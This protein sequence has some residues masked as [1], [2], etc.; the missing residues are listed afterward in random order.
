M[1]S[2]Q[3]LQDIVAGLK[4]M[5]PAQAPLKD[6]IATNTLYAFQGLSFHEGLRQAQQKLGVRTYLDL[7]EYQLLFKAGKINKSVLEWLVSKQK[8][9]E[10]KSQNLE[11]VLEKISETEDSNSAGYR[12]RYRL[13]DLWKKKHELNIIT[14]VHPILFRHMGHFLDQGISFSPV[15]FLRLGFW[16]SLQELERKSFH[17]IFKGGSKSRA[18]HLLFENSWKALAE[19][20]Q[21]LVG[22]E[23]LYERY[24]FEMVQEHPGWSGLVSVIE[25]NPEHLNFSRQIPLHETLAFELLL[26]IDFIDSQLKK[27]GK[28]FCPL[29]NFQDEIDLIENQ[30]P[31]RKESENHLLQLFHNAWEWTNYQELLTGLQANQNQEK[32]RS[33]SAQ[34]FFCIDDRCCSIR[35]HLEEVNPNLETFATPGFF[36]VEFWYKSEWDRFPVKLCPAPLT[37]NFL[38]KGS[39]EQGPKKIVI[40]DALFTRLSHTIFGGWLISQTFGLLSAFRMLLNVLSPTLSPRVAS[41]F[42]HT[43]DRIKLRI[44]RRAENPTEKGLFLGFDRNEMADRVY[45]LLRSSGLTENFSDLVVMMGHGSSTVNNPHYAAY[46]CGAC[47]GRPGSINARIFCMIANDTQVRELVG[48]KGLEIPKTTRFVPGLFD[49]TRDEV[50][51]YDREELREEHL[52]KLIELRKDLEEALLRNSKERSRRFDD[53]SLEISPLEA[54]K[55]LRKKSISIF[56]PRQ[57]FTHS[58]NHS[59]IIGP[60]KLTRGLFLDRRSFMNSYE[61]SLDPQGEIL[62]NILKAAVPVC[63]GINLQYFFSR[64]DNEK[65][66]SGT[67]LPHNV[68]G[69]LSIANGS[70]GDLR[71]GLPQ[72]MI[73]WHEPL[74]L[75]IIVYQEADIALKAAKKIQATFEWIQNDWVKYVSIS[76]TT[77]DFFLFESGEMNRF[78]FFGA[79]P[80]QVK[81]SM[82]LISRS[83][84]YLPVTLIREQK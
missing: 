30:D 20:L 68:V 41:S 71:P 62:C 63:G 52:K 76:P 58:G 28:S 32:V 66:G 83:R 44:F 61:P 8:E 13:R 12:A 24:L 14:H 40:T 74:R 49:T 38:I 57:E 7:Q 78:E 35:R 23:N 5:L 3:H 56:E 59:C 45:G 16:G 31:S 1:G 55:V 33:P 18:H 43:D 26:E 80:P 48:Q 50:T 64:I 15:P 69:L 17:S 47:S 53:V 73:E 67:K 2:E 25:G 60:R 37:P 6:F 46:D 9:E 84:D 72:Q 81:S 29:A 34:I 75:M 21:I 22:S 39:H 82:D 77:G 36:G 19:A 51:F 65:M 27:Q 11:N 79:P 70:E 54:R 10:N 42:R 4:K